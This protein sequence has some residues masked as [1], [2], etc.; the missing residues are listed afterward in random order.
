MAAVLQTKRVKLA[1]SGFLRKL[2]ADESD[3]VLM[4]RHHFK[5]FVDVLKNVGYFKGLERGT[6]AY[7]KKLEEA[8]VT[9]N[10]Q[11]PIHID[12]IDVLKYGHGKNKGIS[13]SNPKL[14][15]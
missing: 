12:T 5:Q 13:T 6:S 10:K 14:W 9:F 7:D 8:R 1:I 15:N 11:Q 4:Q 2:D 3:N